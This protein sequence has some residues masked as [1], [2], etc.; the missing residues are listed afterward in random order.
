MLSC[1][2]RCKRNEK[3][4]NVNFNEETLDCAL[5]DASEGDPGYLNGVNAYQVNKKLFFVNKSDQNK[6][7]VLWK[8]I[9]RENTP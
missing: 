5:L 7:L 9:L 2:H 6:N 4:K 1:V 3:C 8:I